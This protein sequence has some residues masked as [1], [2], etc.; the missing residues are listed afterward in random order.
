VKLKNSSAANV[1]VALIH[2]PVVDKNGK[3]IAAAVTALDLHDIARSAKTYGASAFYVVTPLEDQQELVRRI[4]NHWVTGAGAQ[5]NPDRQT[6]L[7]LIRLQPSLQAMLRDLEDVHG[8]RPRVIA[9]SAR[10]KDNSLSYPD[11]AALARDDRPLLLLF[12]TA[13]GLAD[14]VLQAADHRLAPI[15]GDG[16]YNHLAVRSAAAIILDRLLGRAM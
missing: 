4:I 12:G 11:L 13:W 1:T 3:T 8:A 16:D 15:D 10:K 2:H 14:E 6:A 5:Y 9:T 7:G